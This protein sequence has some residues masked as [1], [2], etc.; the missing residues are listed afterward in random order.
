[1]ENPAKQQKDGLRVLI[2][3]LGFFACFAAVD[4][5]FVYK[6]LSTHKGVVAENAYE[7][8]LHFN[9]II[10]Q[11]RKREHESVTSPEK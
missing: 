2:Y 10:E 7:Q 5:F 4:A 3:L 9:K 11:A 1:M 8:G 6:A